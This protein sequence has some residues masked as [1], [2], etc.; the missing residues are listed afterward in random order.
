M[1]T[2]RYPMRYGLQHYVIVADMPAGLNSSE[3]ALPKAL[4]DQADYR[5][6]AV[7]KW[8]LGFADPSY[9]PTSH[10]FETWFGFLD[11]DNNY[12]NHTTS[13]RDPRAAQDPYDWNQDNAC[14]LPRLVYKI[15]HCL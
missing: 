5:T 9:L 8:H 12:Y 13:Q 15:C 10:G 14:L 7:G 1:L 4:R 11:G 6:H 2:G 3:V